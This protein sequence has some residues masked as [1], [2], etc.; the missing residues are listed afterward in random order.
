VNTHF[1]NAV[2]NSIDGHLLQLG[3]QHEVAIYTRDGVCWVA[4]FRDGRSEL[5][6][7]DTF[8]RFHANALRYSNRRHAA[9][10]E[11]ARALTPEVLE[12][13]ER[14]HQQLEAHDARIR[15]AS[16]AV[17]ASVMRCCRGLTLMIRG[18]TA[19]IA[20]RLS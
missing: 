18:R 13:I 17:V 9:A 2:P 15:D 11:S 4:E 12:R 14:L 19:K 1:E 8:F 20:E 7:A 3:E 6:N 16:V 5:L 10:L